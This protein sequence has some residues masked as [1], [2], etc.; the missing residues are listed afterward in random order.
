MF[1]KGH[2]IVLLAA[3]DKST[4]ENDIEIAR[5]RLAEVLK[6]GEELL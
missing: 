5:L 4:Q 1:Y 2:I 6:Y 3:G